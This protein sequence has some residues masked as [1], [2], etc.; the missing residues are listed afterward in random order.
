MP[1]RLSLDNTDSARRSHSPVPSPVRLSIARSSRIST[2][3]LLFLALIAVGSAKATEHDISIKRIVI[4]RQESAGRPMTPTN[5]VARFRVEIA[6]EIP[7][8]EKGLSGRERLDA[9]AGMLFI[10]DPAS[11]GFFWMKGMN[12]PLDIL[13]FDS[14]RRFLSAA[15]GL[16]PC[17]RCA[18]VKTPD[19]AAY[20]LEI[21]AGLLERLGI[22]EGDNFSFVDD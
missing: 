8:K 10:L 21:N 12:F 3:I 18:W 14:K 11:P 1:I 7:D 9:D 13:F 4:V 19:R 5:P 17:T 2:A 16:Q 20:A 22:R 15:M 6:S